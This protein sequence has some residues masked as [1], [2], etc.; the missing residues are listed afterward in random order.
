MSDLILAQRGIASKFEIWD[1]PTS[2]MSPEGVE[3]LLETLAERARANDKQIWVVEHSSVP[4]GSFSWVV[5]VTR[6][7]DGSYIEVV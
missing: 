3:S 4:M 2:H 6:D 7:V 1:E 5:R